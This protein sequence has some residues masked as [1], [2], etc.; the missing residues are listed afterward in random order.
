MVKSDEE[1]LVPADL[2]NFIKHKNQYKTILTTI[3]RGYE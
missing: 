3:K 1:I 2:P